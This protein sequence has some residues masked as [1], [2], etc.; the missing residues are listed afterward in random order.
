MRILS[1][2]Y[3]SKRLG[4]ATSDLLGYTAQPLKTQNR[5]NIKKDLDEIATIIEEY[6]VAHIVIGLPVNMNGTEA[7]HYQ[8]VLK[9]IEKIKTVSDVPIDTWDERLTT[10]QAERIL[11]EADTSRKKRKK[12]VDKLAATIILQAFMDANPDIVKKVS[13]QL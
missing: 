1:I 2:D 4:L 9:F 7:V 8:D 5:V 6:Q 12:V 10:S 11:I 3:G 13:G